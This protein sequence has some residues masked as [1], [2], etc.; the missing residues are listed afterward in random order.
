MKRILRFYKTW[1]LLFPL[2]M[3]FSYYPIISLGANSTMNFDLSITLIWLVIFDILGFLLLVWKKQLFNFRKQWPWLIMPAYF[4]LSITWSHDKM[5]ALLI[6]GV[7]LS[8]YFAVYSMFTLKD[9]ILNKEYKKSF[10]KSLFASSL[11]IAAWCFIQSILDLAGVSRECTT[12]CPGCTYKTFGFPH[13]NGFAIEPQFMGN[14]LLA[15]IITSMYFAVQ[16]KMF[17]RKNMLIIFA[18]LTTTLFFTL[19]RGAIYAFLIVAFGAVIYWFVKT[20]KCQ[21]FGLWGII[22]LSFIL[23]LNIQGIMSEVSK[24]DD[25]YYSG[26]TKVINQ[27][28]LGKIDLGGLNA[29]KNSSDTTKNEDSIKEV[30]I[31]IE[32]VEPVPE[33]ESSMFGGYIEI[34]TGER[35]DSWKKA[36]TIW[37]NHFNVALFGVGFGSAPLAL[38]EYGETPNAN[39]LIQNQ[40]VNTLFETGIIGFL[41]AAFSVYLIY[42]SIKGMND[43]ILIYLIAGAFAIT[44]VFFSGLPNALH[45]YILPAMLILMLV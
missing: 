25:T 4:A 26:V 6:L 31:D 8:I 45:I 2:A 18:I 3:Y 20:K 43:R 37:K 10:F 29:K 35:L 38:Y 42:K 1:L 34:S 41:L 40:Y 9:L 5:R 11:A 27:L 28:S 32:K 39:D 22:A 19:S 30:N 7:L 23:T 44:L 33:Q 12:M 13:P 21:V 14:L 15:P 24:T 36:L 17:K 16:N